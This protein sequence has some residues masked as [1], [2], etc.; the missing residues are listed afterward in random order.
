MSMAPVLSF[1]FRLDSAG[2][3]VKVD[4]ASDAGI[5]EQINAFV[6]TTRGERPISIGFGSPDPTFENDVDGAFI[7]AGLAEF[8]PEAI[9]TSAAVQMTN[10]GVTSIDV[11]FAV[12]EGMFDA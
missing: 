6:Q 10:D 9:V 1:P 5:A 3:V 8:L 11:E 7:I 4:S 12:N 2:A